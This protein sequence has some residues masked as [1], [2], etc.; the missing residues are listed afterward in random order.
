MEAAERGGALKLGKEQDPWGDRVEPEVGAEVHDACAENIPSGPETGSEARPT[1]WHHPA[2]SLAYRKQQVAG[3]V[4][5]ATSGARLRGAWAGGEGTRWIFWKSPSVSFP[6]ET[7]LVEEKRREQASGSR[8]RRERK[9]PKMHQEQLSWRDVLPF[10]WGTSPTR[11]TVQAGLG[12]GPG[13]GARVQEAGE[14]LWPR[15][16]AGVLGGL[17]QPQ[18]AFFLAG[19]ST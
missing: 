13:A 5:T 9:D 18:Q 11:T 4:A 15:A 3:T 6:Q 10:P 7:K 12:R 8:Q 14:T 1:P 2:L 17:Y 16:R 19:R